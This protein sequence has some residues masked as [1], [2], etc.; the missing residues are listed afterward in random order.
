[1][2]ANVMTRPGIGRWG[3]GGVLIGGV[4]GGEG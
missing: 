3:G 4:G 1:M 2:C